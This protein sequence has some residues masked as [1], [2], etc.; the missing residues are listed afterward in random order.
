MSD[1]SFNTDHGSAEGDNPQPGF[2]NQNEP[3]NNNEPDNNNNDD[4][5]FIEINGRKYSKEDVAKKIEHADKHIQT[6]ESEQEK[7]RSDME[8]M[9][10]QLERLPKLEQALEQ[11]L[12]SGEGERK[13]DIDPEELVN[14]AKQE[15][16]SELERQNQEREYQ[17]NIQKVSQRLQQ[18]FG[19]NPDEEVFKRAA[20][21]GYSR[22]E[23]FELA[24]RKPNA[25]FRMIGLDPAP[26]RKSDPAPTTSSVRTPGTNSR[27]QSDRLP[28]MMNESTTKGRIEAFNQRLAAKKKELGLE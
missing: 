22:E 2:N 13:P 7:Y 20:E 10:S 8:K 21:V 14:R 27:E 6:L 24:G 26:S 19:E 5:G 17:S 15:T 3:G 18:E 23:A 12:Q 28:S 25:F 16:V 1:T 4:Q 11:A 9:L